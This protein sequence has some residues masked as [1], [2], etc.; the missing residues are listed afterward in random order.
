[1][2]VINLNPTKHCNAVV[3]KRSKY[4]PFNYVE[5]AGNMTY[6]GYKYEINLNKLGLSC[7]KLNSSRASSLVEPAVAS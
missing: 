7:A 4:I 1:M 5:L 6:K 3:T 2:Y